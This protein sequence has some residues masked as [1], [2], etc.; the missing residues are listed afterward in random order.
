[1]NVTQRL[2]ELDPSLVLHNEGEWS[3][4]VSNYSA[5]NDGGVE[6]EIGEFFYAMLRMIKPFHVL[7]TG[8]HQGVGAAYMG[9]ALKDNGM[10]VLD[11]I[12]FID[13]HHQFS[14]ERMR[15]LGLD[16]NVTC[17]YG[18]VANWE[19][20][21]PK[22]QFIL[23]DT[24][25]QTRFAEFVKFFPYLEDGGYIFIHDLHR[26]MQQIEIPGQEF[27]WPYG[28]LPVEIQQLFSQ[29]KIRP[30]HFTTPR[31]LT[32]FYKVKEEDYVWPQ[33]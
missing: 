10:G 30:F 21:I 16:S 29:G 6:C 32:G 25:P 27:A 2:M 20:T 3:G 4:T 24:E 33:V 11:T 31:G 13:V 1:M 15:K 18:D 8:T 7:E 23:L 28:K 17:H 14:L 12:E 9:M 22:Y 19:P 5:F 26:H